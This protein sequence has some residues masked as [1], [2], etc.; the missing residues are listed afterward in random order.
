[1]TPLGESAAIILGAAEWPKYAG[2][3]PHPAFRNSAEFFRDYLLG[4]G[5]AQR[6][7]LWLFDDDSQ[8]GPLT[9][10]IVD[11]LRVKADPP[12]RNLL[13]Y[14]VG[15][16][17]Y[18]ERDYFLALR[19]TSDRVRE[20]TILQVRHLA[21]KLN[22]EAPD[23]RQIVI[24]DACYAAGAAG[25][26]MP[27][28][29]GA[30]LPRP[31]E[32]IREELPKT[33]IARG[34]SLFCAASA[35]IEAKTP[36]DGDYTMFSGALRRVLQQGDPDA[37][38]SLSLERLAELVERDIAAQFNGEAVR[39]EV[40]TPRQDK[41][42]I[43]TLPLF[44][45][46]AYTA[47]ADSPRLRA[48]TAELA[49]L[50]RETAP[51]AHDIDWERRSRAEGWYD[52]LDMRKEL[53][54]FGN[55]TQTHLLHGIHG[56][57][58]GEIASRPFGLWAMPAFGTCLLD[59]VTDEQTR[60]PRDYGDLP[61]AATEIKLDLVLTPPATAGTAH[62]GFTIASRLINS[63]A[64]TRLDARLRNHAEIERSM[65]RAGLPTRHLRMVVV[66]P[67]GYAP[68][69]ARITAHPP[70]DGSVP[71][72]RWPEDATET[73]RVSPCL[74]YDRALGCAV[75]QIERALPTFH[76]VLSWKLPPPPTP[77]S[78]A[79]LRAR[80][81]VRSLLSLPADQVGRLDR[82]LGEIRDW[83]CLNHLGLRADRAGAVNLALLAFNE[84]ET[85]AVTQVVA[86]TFADE[87]SRQVALPWGVGLVGWAMRRR[88]PVF[89][90]VRDPA[91]AAI[92]R[93]VPGA[94]KERYVLCVPLPLPSHFDLRQD[95]MLDRSV[96]CVVASLSCAD[97]RGNL[98]RLKQPDG[99]LL[100]KISSALVDKMLDAITR[101]TVQ[102]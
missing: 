22:E 25:P 7:L 43:R 26:F 63:F 79:S 30:G 31:H 87:A 51:L 58:Q 47:P 77:E 62:K 68:D 71:I 97:E 99:N 76:Y 29:D 42:D 5:L 53:D 33:D 90:D 46:A 85:Q 93:Q 100:G 88:S 95:L 4:H 102:S 8:P 32:Q 75:F 14:Y 84:S 74:F 9:E 24:I 78:E 65:I 35:R 98:E 27:Q 94:A 19:C 38:E 28:G 23:K 44:P 57:Q 91:A 82:C 54:P 70:T 21:R 20:Q 60:W 48:L 50:R 18:H 69:Q 39:P 10:R 89:I 16:G 86:A 72:E 61:A 73:A 34:T 40:H 83:I 6:N 67:S 37:S 101:E 41:G 2:F 49:T 81:Q 55:V 15:H 66:F 52:V 96:P 11:F 36:R 13:C 80:E 3:T 92:Y 64:M 12:I 59:R 45:N 1:M 17:G 56:P